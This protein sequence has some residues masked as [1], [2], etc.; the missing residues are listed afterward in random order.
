MYTDAVNRAAI[1]LLAMSFR[2][3]L[4]SR[5]IKQITAAVR[6]RGGQIDGYWL[7]KYELRL[8]CDEVAE[9][10]LTMLSVILRERLAGIADEMDREFGDS[11]QHL[12]FSF[13]PL[14]PTL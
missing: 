3:S 2:P 4:R 7:V 1:A 11:L 5:L 13:T 14:F 9:R 10:A 6:L 8:V 12:L